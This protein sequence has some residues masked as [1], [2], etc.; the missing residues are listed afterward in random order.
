MPHY[1]QLTRYLFSKKFV[2]HQEPMWLKEAF[3]C[4]FNSEMIYQVLEDSKTGKYLRPEKHM[5]KYEK[6]R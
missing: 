2:N 4:A 3:A 1:K 5:L 6:R